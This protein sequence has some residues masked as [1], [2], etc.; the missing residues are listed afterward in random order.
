[1]RFITEVGTL[2]LRESDSN[3]RSLPCFLMDKTQSVEYLLSTSWRS[4]KL[5]VFALLHCARDATRGVL[6]LFLRGKDAERKVFAQ[7]IVDEKHFQECYSNFVLW[8][9]IFLRVISLI[10]T[11]I[12]L[13][14]NLS[15]LGNI[16]LQSDILLLNDT[17][18]APFFT[19]DLN[20]DSPWKAGFPLIAC[21]CP[22]CITNSFF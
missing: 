12:R 15:R 1:M 2:F 21:A 13:A 14:V 6:T 3:L 19:Y 17:H 7:C 20:I 8:R 10:R 5:E 9:K 16:L 11:F 22:A 4:S 18:G